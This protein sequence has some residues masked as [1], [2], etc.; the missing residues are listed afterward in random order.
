MRRSS[1]LVPR[2][3]HH[4]LAVCRACNWPIFHPFVF[5]PSLSLSFFFLSFFSF[6]LRLEPKELVESR[7][8]FARIR[9]GKKKGHVHLSFFPISLSPWIFLNE[10]KRIK[11]LHESSS[12]R[13]SFL[14]SSPPRIYSRPFFVQIIVP[15]TFPILTR[16]GWI[17]I[18][19]VRFYSPLP[20][21]RKRKSIEEYDRPWS[22]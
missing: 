13:I 12:F 15:R 10:T 22:R 11:G 14:P 1:V 3:V 20:R 6:F 5:S 17:L 8:M 9:E 7:R 2:M 16:I 19:Y 18:L 4:F 21:N